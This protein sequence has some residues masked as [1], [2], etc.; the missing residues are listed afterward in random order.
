MRAQRVAGGDGAALANGPR[1]RRADAR[2]Q[3]RALG[4]WTLRG[5]LL[6]D[7][8]N[9]CRRRQDEQRRQPS[10]AADGGSVWYIPVA[11][12]VAHAG[13]SIV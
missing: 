6:S 7:R 10:P 3:A 1:R 5:L 2:G 9:P 12:G 11:V 13:H 4:I 8:R